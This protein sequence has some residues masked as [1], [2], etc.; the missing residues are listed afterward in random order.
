MLGQ[1]WVCPRAKK[2]HQPFGARPCAAAGAKFARVHSRD[3]LESRLEP[4]SVTV[5]ASRLDSNGS[6]SDAAWVFGEEIARTTGGVIGIG[7]GRAG[8]AGIGVLFAVRAGIMLV[9][10]AA[11]AVAAIGAAGV[12]TVVAQVVVTASGKARQEGCRQ[13]KDSAFHG[14]P[15]QGGV[16]RPEDPPSMARTMDGIGGKTNRIQRI[17][18]VR[19]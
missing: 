5:A 13:Q 14:S 8:G 1:N 3:F 19:N 12:A 18:N 10:S 4:A 9:R 17:G 11:T 7:H 6:R 16:R 2:P 15:P